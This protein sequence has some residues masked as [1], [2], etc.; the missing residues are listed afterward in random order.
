MHC[1]HGTKYFEPRLCRL[2]L[3]RCCIFYC[4]TSTTPE[5][6]LRHTVN[7][8]DSGDIDRLWISTIP[9][10]NANRHQ[11][12][13]VERALVILYPMRVSCAAF[14][15]IALCPQLVSM[16]GASGGNRF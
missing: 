11:P 15:V 8:W 1:C 16:M 6:T 2:Q 3:R 9:T 10:T 12:I 4:A 13:H 7:P 5:I 14:A